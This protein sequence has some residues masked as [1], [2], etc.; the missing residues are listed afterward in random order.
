M[1]K[2]K[3]QAEIETLKTYGKEAKLLI[4]KLNSI[5]Q[6]VNNA[7]E[8]EISRIKKKIETDLEELSKYVSDDISNT[9]EINISEYLDKTEENYPVVYLNI[10]FGQ[11]NYS[12]NER[13]SNDTYVRHDIAI[14][15]P[16]SIYESGTCYADGE[17]SNSKKEHIEILCRNWDKII[18]GA[19]EKIKEAY[20]KDTEKKITNAIDSSEKANVRY[21]ALSSIV[22]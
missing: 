20:K 4:E 15:E 16:C 8:D 3:L 18:E 9:K 13:P 17:W 12:P 22:D 7:A 1:D 10:Q 19:Y 2:N 21:S 5:T 6:E 11:K 14:V